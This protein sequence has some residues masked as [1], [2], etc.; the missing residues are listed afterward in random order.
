MAGTV[1][2]K[3]SL[4]Y[5][6]SG[7][8]RAGG[9]T[10]HCC[11]VMACFC[12]C[13]RTLL[14][15]FLICLCSFYF[16]FAPLFGYVRL[17]CNL[18][19]VKLVSWKRAARKSKENLWDSWMPSVPFCLHSVCREDFGARKNTN[20]FNMTHP[21][22]GWMAGADPYSFNARSTSTVARFACCA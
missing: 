18:G 20:F 8:G 6:A 19:L 22:P 3:A 17:H 4:F 2:W 7:V 11:T 14:V 13:F 16:S 5:C 15:F 12:P 10:G 1:P 21:D 9:R